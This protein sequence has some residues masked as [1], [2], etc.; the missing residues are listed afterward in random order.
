MS[1]PTPILTTYISGS[2]LYFMLMDPATLK[3]WNTN[4]LAF[5]TYNA[6]NWAQ[7]VIA[8][9][10]IGATGIFQAAF[11][12]Q[13]ITITPTAIFYRQ[14]GGSPVTSDAPPI[15]VGPPSGSNIAAINN[16]VSAAEILQQA[17]DSAQGNVVIIG[18]S[19]LIN[20]LR[21]LAQDT[22]QSHT[23]Y[24]E[25]LGTD[26]TYPINGSNVTFQLKSIP[27]VAASPFTS[28][29]WSVFVTLNVSGTITPRSQVGFSLTDAYNGIITFDSAPASGTLI[30]A[31]YNY[32]WFPDA[33][34]SE[35]LIEAAQ[36]TLAGVSDPSQIIEG[37]IEVM[38]QYGLSHFAMA[39]ASFFGEQI[40]ASGGDQSQDAQTKADFYLNMS[41]SA[42]AKAKELQTL[43]YQRQG[44]RN[45][46][47]SGDIQH[48]WDPVSPIR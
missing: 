46:P 48:L 38:L 39:R 42:Y 19:T 23:I 14:S 29:Q 32:L 17:A 37:L 16:D 34:Y 18:A 33:S 24:R 6:S 9:T 4:T 15:Q 1:G 40:R 12:T 31:D 30:S 10:E 41:K 28:P 35:W 5:E 43:F 20:K 13:I 45:A 2:N 8:M 26:P 3:F 27:V 36:E 22:V 44:Q 47:A 25:S 11:P 21:I 7:Y